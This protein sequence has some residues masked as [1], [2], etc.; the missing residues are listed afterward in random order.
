MSARPDRR[1]ARAPS[2]G[3]A[4]AAQI[5]LIHV[6]RRE[7]LMSDDEYRDLL[8]TMFGVR[9]SATLDSRE[10]KA[11]LTRFRSLGWQYRPSQPKQRE[12]H[13]STDDAAA[14]RWSMARTIWAQLHRA[15]AVRVDT[16]AALMSYVTRQTHV[17]HWRFLSTIQINTV[18]ESLKRWQQRVESR[19]PS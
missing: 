19:E 13:R 2:R 10:R 3:A 9:S 16:D 12:L 14:D 1:A 8:H 11:L 18:I 17:E 4:R 5:K 6:A 7:L 15:G